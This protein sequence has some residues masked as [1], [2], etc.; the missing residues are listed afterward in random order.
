MLNGTNKGDAIHIGHHDIGEQNINRSHLLGKNRQ[1]SR[2]IVGGQD[3][4]IMFLEHD[5][6]K[7]ENIGFVVDDQNQLA[8]SFQGFE[9]QIGSD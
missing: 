2:R 1:R 3:A 5:P 4:I 8:I 7:T 9:G 6:G